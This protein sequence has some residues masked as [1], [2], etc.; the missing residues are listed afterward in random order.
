M[1]ASSSSRS[2][3]DGDFAA[4]LGQRLEGFG[5]APLR[6]NSRAL[7]SAVATCAANWRRMFDVALGEPIAARL[8]ML[9][10]PIGRFLCISGTTSVGAMPGTTST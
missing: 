6:S 4:D 9:S 8:R 3:T 5:V 7:T 2:S 10:A 1:R